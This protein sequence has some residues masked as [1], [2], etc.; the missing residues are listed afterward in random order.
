MYGMALIIMAVAICVIHVSFC[1][2]AIHAHAPV[3]YDFHPYLG[4]VSDLR[5]CASTSGVSIS[6]LS[7]F[8][9]L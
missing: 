9:C 7:N 1:A 8:C 4:V 2:L 5:S 6:V 3:L